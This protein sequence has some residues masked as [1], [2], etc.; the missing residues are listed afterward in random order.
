MIEITH[1]RVTIVGL[2]ITMI[3]I[4]AA[5]GQTLFPIFASMLGVSMLVA[6]MMWIAIGLIIAGLGVQ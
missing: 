5:L 4:G 6:S 1:G 3:A 2:C